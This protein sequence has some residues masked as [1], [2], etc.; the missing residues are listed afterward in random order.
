MHLIIFVPLH[1]KFDVFP[2]QFSIV[3][4]FAFLYFAFQNLFIPWNLS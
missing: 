3:E 4:F 1:A 2:L